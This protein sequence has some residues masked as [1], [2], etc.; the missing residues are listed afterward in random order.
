[1][2]A[3][4]TIRCASTNSSETNVLKDVW[5]LM[6]AKMSKKETMV[7]CVAAV[8]S[9]AWNTVMVNVIGVKT[10]TNVVSAGITAK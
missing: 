6:Y 10:I 1:M 3:I 8:W 4:P 9:L 2:D 7:N 5:K